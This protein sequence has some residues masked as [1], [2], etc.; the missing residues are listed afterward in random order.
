MTECPECEGL[1]DMPVWTDYD[2]G[3]FEIVPCFLCDGAGELTDEE[4]KRYEAQR[5]QMRKLFPEN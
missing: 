4:L 5:E 1:K 3:K 2:K